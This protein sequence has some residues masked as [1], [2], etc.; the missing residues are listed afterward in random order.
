MDI[1]GT[2]LPA[3][4]EKWFVRYLF[5]NRLVSVYKT[6]G[7]AFHLW[8]WPV[9]AHTLKLVY[10]AGCSEDE[11]RSWIQSAWENEIV[12]RIFPG[13]QQAIPWL[14]KQGCTIVLLSGTP[15]PLAQP[16]MELFHIQHALCAE[17]EIIAQHYSGRLLKPH[18]R[19]PNKSLYASEWLQTHGL[20]W[21][22]AIALA[23]DWQDRFL[24]NR[25]TPVVVHPSPRLFHLAQKKGWPMV[26]NPADSGQIIQIIQ[27]TL[28][29][30]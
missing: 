30:N 21:K 9:Q 6:V 25:A 4:L 15:R 13:W 1:D 20:V 23:N 26:T 11:V 12:H 19:G 22:D 28:Q 18:P 2:L 8:H 24:L 29:D 5:K 10:L 7:H 14:Q 3:S 16:L 17:P 27:K